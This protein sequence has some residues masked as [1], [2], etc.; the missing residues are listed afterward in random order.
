MQTSETYM[1]TWRARVHEPREHSHHSH[2]RQNRA[3]KERA[4]AL[5]G[6]PATSR[7]RHLTT[8]LRITVG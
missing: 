6:P 8:T 2:I 4:G 3:S 1:I 5:P 7:G